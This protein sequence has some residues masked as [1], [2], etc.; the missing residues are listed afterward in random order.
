MYLFCMLLEIMYGNSLGM[1]GVNNII[2]ELVLNQLSIHMKV[3]SL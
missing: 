1:V 3:P 2:N